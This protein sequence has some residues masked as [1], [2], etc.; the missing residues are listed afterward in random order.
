MRYYDIIITEISSGN[1]VG[2]ITSHPNGIMNAP[3]RGALDVE[4]SL[5]I[6]S[7][8]MASPSGGD[9]SNSHLRIWGVPLGLLKLA[10]QFSTPQGLAKYNIQVYG[11]M[12]KGLPLANPSLAGLLIQGS[13]WRAV[14]TWQGTNQYLDMYFAPLP[15]N[16]G[17]SSG[18]AS[19]PALMGVNNFSFHWATGEPLAAA[20]NA[21]LQTAYPG[22]PR[23]ILVNPGLVLDRDETG[24]YTTLGE[25]ADFINRR[26]NAILGPNNPLYHGVQITAQDG[27]IV[28]YDG[29]GAGVTSAAVMTQ[30]GR[31]PIQV[32]DLGRA[33][34][35]GVSLSQ[36]SGVSTATPNLGLEGNLSTL[37]FEPL[38]NKT[39]A[40]VGGG[41]DAYVLYGVN[42]GGVIMQDSA[43]G[44]ATTVTINKDAVTI[45]VGGG[46]PVNITAG[47]SLSP[48]M[49][50]AGPSPVLSADGG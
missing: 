23:K 5:S 40:A 20:I 41:G 35:T 9:Y 18:D 12:G 27:A 38:G 1:Q 34:P 36:V 29:S 25:F 10:D 7:Y 22:V 44:S 16:G 28:V 19:V 13:I 6:Y 4:F 17:V 42:G 48:V 50:V 45:Q 14:G 49:T 3:D 47:G 26:T 15:P 24:T 2:R 32:G 43:T 11:G 30:Y 8:A 46:K 39:W 31:P 37:A 21:T 33:I